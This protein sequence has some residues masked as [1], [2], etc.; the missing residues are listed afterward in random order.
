MLGAAEVPDDLDTAN[1]LA[2][3]GAVANEAMRLRPVA[4]LIVVESIEATMIGDVEIPANTVVVVLTRPPTTDATHFPDPGA[5]NPARW[6][7]AGKPGDGGGA[8]VNTGYIPFGSGPRICPGRS[9]AL[10]EMKVVLALL[11]RSF[12]VTR[13]GQS[14]D[15]REHFAFTMSPEGLKVHLQRR[16]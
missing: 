8:G 1:R 2:Y 6:L 13:D 10:V 4:P 14:G 9:L 3:A 12:V 5:F 11:Y 7:D 15:V 16:T